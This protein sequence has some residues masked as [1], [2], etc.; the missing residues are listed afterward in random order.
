MRRKCKNF[1]MVHISNNIRGNALLRQERI[2]RNLR[3]HDLAEQLGTTAVTIKRWEGGRQQPSAYFR[4]KLCALFGK[5]AEELGLIPELYSLTFPLS[6]SEETDVWSVPFPRNPFFTGREN[7]L[8]QLH[9]VLTSRSP[10]AALTRSYALSG[11]GGIGKTQLAVEYAY[12]YRSEYSAVLWVESETLAS[13]NASFVGL[14]GVLGLP[15]QKEEDQSKIAN[16]VLHWLNQHEEWLLIFD[17]VEDLA[18][19]KPFLP[20]NDRG[21]LL[22][23]TRLQALGTLAQLLK[24]PPMNMQEGCDFLLVRTNQLH[25]NAEEI[26]ADWQERSIA[27]AIVTQM[28]GLPLALEQAGAYIDS[29][30]CSFSGYLQLFHDMQYYLLDEHDAF[31]GH[32]LSVSRT[33]SLA[34]ERVEQRHPLAAELLT[35]CAFLAPDAIPEEFFREGAS[36]LGRVFAEMT[37]NPLAFQNASKVLLSYSLLQRHSE[38]QTLSIH[39]LV[40]VVLRQRMSKAEQD[41]WLQRTLHF[42]SA[43]FPEENYKVWRQCERLLPHVLACVALVPESCEDLELA[44]LLQKAATYLYESGQQ[45]EQA[46]AWC[47][48]ALRIH[49]QV[50]GPEHPAVAASLYELGCIY[51]CV[52][53]Y[54]EIEPLYKQALSIYERTLGLENPEVAR[55]LGGLALLSW[56]QGKYREAEPFQKRVVSIWQRLSKP[57]PIEM[58]LALGRLGI[59]Y[60]NQGKH[61]MAEPLYEQALSIYRQTLGSEHPNLAATLNNLADLY[62]MQRKYTEAE[63]LYQQASHIWSVALGPE[64]P[65]MATVYCNLANL[66]CMQ[67]RYAE[68]QPLYEQALRIWEMAVGP[69]HPNTANALNGLAN[70]FRD[71]GKYE[72]ARSFYQRTLAMRLQHLGP[73]H[74]SVAETLHDFAHF[75]YLRQETAEALVL[76]QRVQIIREQV[77]GE[78]HPK[79][80]ETRNALD[81]LLQ[82]MRQR[83]DPATR[84]E[85]VRAAGQSLLCAC[86]C[87]RQIDRSKSRGEPRRFFSEACKQ[88]FYRNTQRQKRNVG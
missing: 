49:L 77:Y 19:I 67:R 20:T 35:I 48:R 33:F 5:S 62:Q 82:K 34:F 70:L 12:Q 81:R 40:Q 55:V 86:G 71:Q 73:E 31:N 80:Q 7:I 58:A 28:G 13:L 85:F 44:N 51:R 17:N 54:D 59:I 79:T 76:Y 37:I 14:A 43:V 45:H 16:A 84:E 46:V 36:A 6:E 75:H 68:A 10:S 2:Q 66:F 65:N 53:R 83:Q 9:T 21:A 29:T 57:D 52:G 88:R 18:L 38:M 3:Q 8:E 1:Y 25:Q 47:Q 24:I 23:T 26:V 72:Q 27:E 63:R 39:R 61:E 42:L 15:E 50:L 11:M 22:L 87:G 30:K 41:W 64:H 60:Q 32:P 4:V 74:P 69:W 56:V 78:Q